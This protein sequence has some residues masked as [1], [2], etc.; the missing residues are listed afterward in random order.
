MADAIP[1]ADAARRIGI[2]P[3][4]L[5]ERR[6]KL[7]LSSGSVGRGNGAR[8][9]EAELAMLAGSVEPPAELLRKAATIDAAPE[10]LA[11]A[12]WSLWLDEIAPAER[13][14]QRFFPYQ[15]DA[16]VAVFVAKLI[17][18][19]WDAFTYTLRN[20]SG[21]TGPLAIPD[22]IERLRSISGLPAMVA[23]KSDTETQ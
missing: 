19:T 12:A 7:G 21:I 10:L 15:T 16:K 3:K 6:R 22:E 2:T 5:R 11:R 14:W 9:S 18:Y 17:A 4:T 23:R 20:E 1:I 8:I 13:A